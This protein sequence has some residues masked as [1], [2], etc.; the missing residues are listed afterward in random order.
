M[1]RLFELDAARGDAKP[2]ISYSWKGLETTAIDD[3]TADLFSDGELAERVRGARRR[4][5]TPAPDRG[6]RAHRLPPLDRCRDRRLP[7]R[8][9]RP[10]R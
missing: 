10:S 6:A 7:R 8:G 9:E 3:T 5:E 2:G 4:D 1:K